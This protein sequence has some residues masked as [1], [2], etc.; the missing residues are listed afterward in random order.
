[1]S[2]ANL[3]LF[4]EKYNTSDYF[5]SVVDSLLNRLV[6]FGYISSSKASTLLEVLMN[7]IKEIRFGNN[8]PYD[9]KS[10]YYDANKKEL[11]I[12]DEKNIPAVYLRLLYALTTVETDI[13]VFMVGY[14]TTKLRKDSYRLAYDN[15]GIN[16]AVIANLVYKL[17]NL[18][19]DSLMLTPTTKTHTHDFLGLK[20]EANNDLYSLEGKL[21]SELC[22]VLDLDAELLYS[23]LFAKNPAKYLNSIFAKK[24]FENQD[25]FLKLFDDISRKYN[26]YNKLAYLSNRLNDNYLDY[27][28]HVLNDNIGDILKEQEII[29]SQIKTVISSLYNKDEE[30]QDEFEVET[31]LAEAL[32]TLET[33]LKDMLV[34]FQDILCDN[35]IKVNSAL[36]YIK[37]ASKLKQFNDIL[38]VP[39]K[40]LTKAIQDTILFKLMPTDEVTGINLIQKIKY[41]IIEQILSSEDYTNISNSFSF[42]NITNL[43]NSD[44]GTAIILLN[45][46]KKFAKIIEVNGLNQNLKNSFQFELNYIPLDNLK[47]IMNT[48]YT[49]TY[50]GN[51]E[52][53]FTALKDNFQEL[54]NIPLDNIFVFEYNSEKF[55]VAYCNSNIYVISYVYSSRGYGFNMLNLSEQYKVFGKTV[56]PKSLFKSNLPMLYNK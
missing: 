45:S 55:I 1:M 43:E 56:S 33:E 6:E 52:K 30:Q 37:Y 17:C 44:L 16:R 10:G 54:S 50:I 25:K 23:G 13:N 35:I 41:A 11:Y 32:E 2:R 19:P 14:S 4:K 34:L 40:K 5:T 21:L 8:N 20:I 22:Y 28:K 18:I 38:I 47:Y 12:K 7:N 15:F 24:G 29:E 27:K 49:T 51:V 39:N 9:Y 46:D 3:T 42:Y 26:T 31:G 48:S 53:L 36:P